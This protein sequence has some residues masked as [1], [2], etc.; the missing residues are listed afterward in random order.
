MDYYLTFYQK[1]LQFVF[2]GVQRATAQERMVFVWVIFPRKIDH[3]E[4]DIYLYSKNPK[5][6]TTFGYKTCHKS[7]Y[8]GSMYT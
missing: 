1:V 6:I 2:I 3:T 7:I 8:E 5:V 4:I